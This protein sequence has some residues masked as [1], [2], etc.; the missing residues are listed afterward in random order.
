MTWT[1]SDSDPETATVGHDHKN[2][3]ILTWHCEKLQ[4]LA[5]FT[6]CGIQTS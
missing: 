1:Y 4:L 5:F 2:N 3:L 6:D